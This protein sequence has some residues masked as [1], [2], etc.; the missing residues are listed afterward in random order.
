MFTESWSDEARET[1]SKM[2]SKEKDRLNAIIAMDVMVNNMN[3]ETAYMR[4]IYIVPDCASEWDY[5]DFATNDEGTEENHLFDEAVELFKKLWKM[6]ASKDNGLY[7]GGKT[8]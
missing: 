5:I 2:S 3:D 8:Y 1:V 4:W 7:I 6:Y